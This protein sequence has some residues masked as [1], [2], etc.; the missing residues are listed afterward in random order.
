MHLFDRRTAPT[1]TIVATTAY[2]MMTQSSP[3]GA[4][5]PL[6]ESPEM[7]DQSARNAE[8]QANAMRA[9]TSPSNI[10]ASG[11]LTWFSRPQHGCARQPG[12]HEP[13]PLS[14][15]L[16]VR[17]ITPMAS[18]TVNSAYTNAATTRPAPVP[19]MARISAS[20]KAFQA[21][22]FTKPNVI[23]I[24]MTRPTSVP[25]MN[26]DGIQCIDC[27]H[28]ACFQKS[29]SLKTRIKM[30]IRPTVSASATPRSTHTSPSS[31]PPPS[32]TSCQAE[33]ESRQKETLNRAISALALSPPW[34]L[35]SSFSLS[36][37]STK[38]ERIETMMAYTTRLLSPK[39]SFAV[40]FSASFKASAPT[41]PMAALPSCLRVLIIS[42]RDGQ[43]A[44]GSSNRL[45]FSMRPMKYRYCSF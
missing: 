12:Q 24:H 7:V 2:M 44:I 21:I 6:F 23:G 14:F 5:L 18:G 32:I 31:T 4:S 8:F 15:T 35:A 9:E 43:Q 22:P 30:M 38:I 37:A 39:I 36:T 16:F 45:F 3:L 40:S 41:I 11:S 20:K 17:R 10:A 29:Y 25:L 26:P 13:Q 34:A 28:A 42:S 1:P 19:K 33:A 27:L